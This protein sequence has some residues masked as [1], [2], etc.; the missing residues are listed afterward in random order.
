MRTLDPGSA[1]QMLK[2]KT[3]MIFFINLLQT[4]C[5]MILRHFY[6]YDNDVVV[7]FLRKM[8]PYLL[9]IQTEAFT[10]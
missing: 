2:N 10:N 8:R 7:L 6:R 1:K 3:T 9:E 5:L 4:G